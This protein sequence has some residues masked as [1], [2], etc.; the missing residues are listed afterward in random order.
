MLLRRAAMHQLL[1]FVDTLVDLG[2]SAGIQCPVSAH[3]SSLFTLGSAD[4]F[5]SLQLVNYL[6]SQPTHLPQESFLLSNLDKDILEQTWI[7]H[8]IQVIS[9]PFDIKATQKT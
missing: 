5:A 3:C 1:S 9:Y 6:T 7:F 2:R 4:C 8:I